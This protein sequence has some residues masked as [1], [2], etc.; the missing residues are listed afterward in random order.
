VATLLLAA[1]IFN[2]M[3][4]VLQVVNGKAV[5]VYEKGEGYF[6]GRL[7]AQLVDCDQPDVDL[8]SFSIARF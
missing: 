6:F 5:R 8:T 2:S 7:K 4:N 3:S 1:E